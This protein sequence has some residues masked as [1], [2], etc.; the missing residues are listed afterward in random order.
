MKTVDQAW[1][2]RKTERGTT[3]SCNPE[4]E[5]C[6][7]FEAGHEAIDT[8]EPERFRALRMIHIEEQFGDCVEDGER[9][10]CKTISILDWVPAEKEND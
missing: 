4:T 6:K 2:A 5:F 7:G 1:Q 10:P 3:R 9:Y 8:A